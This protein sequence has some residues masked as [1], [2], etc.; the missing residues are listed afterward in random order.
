MVKKKKELTYCLACFED[1]PRDDEDLRIVVPPPPYLKLAFPEWCVYVNEG[2]IQ[3]AKGD[4]P[5][6]YQ[7]RYIGTEVSEE[8][9]D[10]MRKF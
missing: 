2:K 5:S 1:G 7:F 10:Q 3:D 8:L 6:M 4:R 9:K